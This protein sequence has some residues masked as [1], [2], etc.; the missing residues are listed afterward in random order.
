MI[1]QEAAAELEAL[2][3]RV[4]RIRPMSERNPHAFYEERSEVASEIRELAMKFRGAPRRM[5][6]YQVRHANGR[7][8]LE[9]S[10]RDG[11]ARD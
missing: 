4:A 7:T 8:V 2:A 5:P 10:Q 3:A 6:S 9:L 1:D 11:R